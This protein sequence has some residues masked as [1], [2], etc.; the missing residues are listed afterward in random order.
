MTLVGELFDGGGR[1]AKGA[2]SDAVTAGYSKRSSCKSF[3]L[4]NAALLAASE[5]GENAPQVHDEVNRQK[6]EWGKKARVR[7]KVRG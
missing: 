3:L 6:I 7:H 1:M 5:S 4:L 2:R